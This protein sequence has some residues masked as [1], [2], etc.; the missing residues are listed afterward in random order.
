MDSE[1]S[2]Y[3]EDSVESEEPVDSVV[4]DDEVESEVFCEELFCKL[5]LE[6]PQIK[7]A[8]IKNIKTKQNKRFMIVSPVW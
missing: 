8:I 5:L 1:D 2:V 3:S 7:T 4:S 6:Q